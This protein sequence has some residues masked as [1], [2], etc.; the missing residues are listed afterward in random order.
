MTLT[1]TTSEPLPVHHGPIEMT[2]GDTGITEERLSVGDPFGLR[3][4][5]RRPRK[6]IWKGHRFAPA[7]PEA[8]LRTFR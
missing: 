1:E 4:F 2:L 8:A 6:P 7:S 3:R 5:R